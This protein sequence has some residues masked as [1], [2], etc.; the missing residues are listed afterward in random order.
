MATCSIA[1]W[2]HWEFWGMFPLSCLWVYFSPSLHEN[3]FLIQ[4]NYT[5]TPL[6]SAFLSTVSSSLCRIWI[7]LDKN[8]HSNKINSLWVV[9]KIFLSFLSSFSLRLL[10][11]ELQTSEKK[12]MR[13]CTGNRTEYLLAWIPM[14]CGNFTNM[15]GS[16]LYCLH[17][18][19]SS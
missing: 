12:I 16:V 17:T 1:L 11:F 19:N 4:K 8:K 7:E 5:L 18:Q 13:S 6:P 10:F 14:S 3:L 2:N 9:S 15:C